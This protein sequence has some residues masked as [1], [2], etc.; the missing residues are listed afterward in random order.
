MT[1]SEIFPRKLYPFATAITANSNTQTLVLKEKFK[2][3]SHK[4]SFVPNG[5]YLQEYVYNPNS[6]EV[7]IVA[8]G[9]VSEL[10]DTYL[11]LSTLNKLVRNGIANVKVEWIGALYEWN[12]HQT[13]YYEKCEKFRVENNLQDYWEW[14]G[15]VDNVNDYLRKASL[16]VHVLNGEGFPNALCE[17]MSLGIPVVASDFADHG[18]IVTTDINGYLV[19]MKDGEGLYNS[20]V[21]FIELTEEKRKTMSKN[22]YSTA[23]EKFSLEKMTENYLTLLQ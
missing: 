4:I 9:R 5:V 11:L 1:D 2:S 17:A 12:E 20:I 7:K 13:E 21:K 23:I 19:K 18:L 10:K 6:N 16:A 14:I 22:A 15:Q 3:L 8:I